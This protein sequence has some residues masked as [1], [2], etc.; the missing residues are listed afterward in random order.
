MSSDISGCR[1]T[2]RWFVCT[3][4][5]WIQN[6]R[7]WL[8]V[9]ESVWLL[10][11][12]NELIRMVIW[13]SEVS[14][15]TIAEFPAAFHCQVFFWIKR[16]EIKLLR[17]S[18]KQT[19][20]I[21]RRSPYE[22][23]A[24]PDLHDNSEVWSCPSSSSSWPKGKFWMPDGPHQRLQCRDGSGKQMFMVETFHSRI[25]PSEAGGGLGQRRMCQTMCPFVDQCCHL[26]C[27]LS[28]LIFL[29]SSVRRP[30]N[31]YI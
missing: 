11:K 30:F 20:F 27:P 22:N 8:H 4:P 23:C 7:A 5:G 26:G 25:A 12:I 16:W 29:K 31:K 17:G 2:A 6:D 19:I 18:G 28:S 9:R 15:K 10:K 24:A 1:R 3:K 21:L 14:L 13:S